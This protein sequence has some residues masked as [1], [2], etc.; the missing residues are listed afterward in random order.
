MKSTKSTFFHNRAVGRLALTALAGL[1]L[2]LQACSEPTLSAG[3]GTAQAEE[4]E[5]A[6]VATETAQGSGTGQVLW[7]TQL[8]A[9]DWQSA[10]NMADSKA[11]GEENLEIVDAS[12]NTFQK[13][14]R[15]YYPA[16][17]VS[18]SFAR[19]E[20]APLGGSQFYADL[21]IPAQE[22]LRLSYY[23]RFSP[24]F[25]FVKGGKLP[26]LYGGEGGSGGN[27][28][29]GQNGFSTRFMWRADGDGE[30]YAYLPT[31]RRFG[32]SIGQGDWRFQPG[33]WHHLEQE[34]TLNQP[35][36]ADG[37]VR[38]WLDGQ[39]VLDQV[40][41]IFRSVDSLK[42]DGVFFSTFFG[43]SDASWATPE[44][45]HVDFANFSVSVP[46]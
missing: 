1:P 45:V 5:V 33:V 37:R 29:D 11:W 41:L 15:V 13:A 31:S 30:V 40:G 7:S 26:G 2:L 24:N 12:E 21:G 19:K 25:D 35:G 44:D 8:D 28:P 43:G 16:G 36:M 18:P 46:E 4:S 22:S 27:I 3:G 17:S 39:L 34:I 23:L 38:V 10:W 20:N 6:T 14:L 42:I 9:G 32:T